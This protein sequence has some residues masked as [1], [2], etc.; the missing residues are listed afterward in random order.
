MFAYLQGR[1]G[2]KEYWI[3]VVLLLVVGVGLAYANVGGASGAT[4]FLWI[5]IWNRRLHDIGQSGWIILIPLGLI[6]LGTAAGL[7]LGGNE[8]LNAFEYSQKGDGPITQRGAL[9]FDG[10]VLVLLAIQFGF[11]IWLGVRKGDAGDNRFG[12][13]P[14]AF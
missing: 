1:S 8:V 3:G 6:V 7:L 13:P 9:L 10:M 12:P 4:T 2:R 11:T 14:P 5:L